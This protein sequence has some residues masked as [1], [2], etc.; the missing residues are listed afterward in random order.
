[1]RTYAS[2]NFFSVIT[3]SVE[4]TWPPSLQLQQV[5]LPVEVSPQVWRQSA[6]RA[7]K[8]PEGVGL[9]SPSSL[10][11]QQVALPAEVSPQVWRQS[12][13]RATKGPEG[14]GLT[15]P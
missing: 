12:A 3:G 10:R 9:T 5:A 13:L 4:L 6:L 8:G 14:V 1:M 11:P 15:W 2:L 7:T